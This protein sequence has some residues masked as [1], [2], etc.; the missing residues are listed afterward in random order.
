MVMTSAVPAERAG[1]A[2]DV[3]VG[4]V[5]LELQ[6]VDRLP[7]GLQR[8]AF[9]FAAVERAV[10]EIEEVVADA[11]RDRA[12]A[13]FAEPRS[14]GGAAEGA[15]L[16]RCSCGSRR[17]A[18]RRSRHSRPGRSARSAE[19]RA[20]LRLGLQLAVFSRKPNSLCWSDSSAP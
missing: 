20:G 18:T 10:G 15:F 4:I 12:D 8:D 2:L 16:G 6:E 1:R 5:E 11:E 7:R 3:E 19:R 14:A 13:I 9:L 17:W